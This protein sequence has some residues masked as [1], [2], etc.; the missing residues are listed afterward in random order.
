MGKPLVRVFGDD[1]EALPWTPT[2]AEGVSEKM[3]ALDAD[4]GSWSRLLLLEAGATYTREGGWLYETYVLEGAGNLDPNVLRTG[5][6]VCS[7]PGADS[8]EEISATERTTI[9]EL[10]DRSLD[11]PAAAW[12]ADRLESEPWTPEEYG[13][14]KLLTRGESGSDTLLTRVL[15]GSEEEPAEAHQYTEEILFI[16]G[17]CE[18]VGVGPNVALGY[19]CFPP[20]TMHGP[21]TFDDADLLLLEINNYS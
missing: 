21:Y 17:F 8:T 9:F 3:L 6:Y 12:P 13:E 10:R 7:R 1:L 14:N 19:T 18:E 11:K 5:A 20:G 2:G 15:K 4:D 16:E